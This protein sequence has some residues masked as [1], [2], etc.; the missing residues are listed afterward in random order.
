[1]VRKLLHCMGRQVLTDYRLPSSY[2]EAV[3]RYLQLQASVSRLH[4]VGAE[5]RVVASG[6]EVH[7]RVVSIKEDL[8]R[9]VHA[10]DETAAI[11]QQY[12]QEF[13]ETDSLSEA[14][15]EV[16]AARSSTEAMYSNLADVTTE[17]RMLVVPILL[18]SK[19]PFDLP[20]HHAYNMYRRSGCCASSTGSYRNSGSIA[21]QMG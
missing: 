1:M 7:D 3:E 6:P 13:P 12:L 18:E 10:L 9:L 11:W 17:M 4:K 8:G 21:G 16:Q 5:P 15:T 14:L 2:V 19:Q 20:L